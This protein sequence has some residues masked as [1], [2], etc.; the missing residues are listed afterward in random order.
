MKGNNRKLTL[1]FFFCISILTDFVS[2]Q[3]NTHTTKVDGRGLN[4]GLLY[5][6]KIGYIETACT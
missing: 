4:I 3:Q 2:E 5:R 6:R 1:S